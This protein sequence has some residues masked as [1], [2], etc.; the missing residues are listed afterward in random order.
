[1]T[2]RN[3]RIFKL[4]LSALFLAMAMILPFVTGQIPKLGNAFLPMH[5]PILLCGFF[6]GPIY[7]TVVGAVAP[8]LRFLLFG[9]P[10]LM[11]MGISMS[12]ELATYGL[13]A[14]LL[15]RL[16]PKK[17]LFVYLSLIG[18]MIAGRITWGIARVILYGMGQAPFGW[19]A[20]L[21]GAFL[22]AIPGIVIQIL[23]IPPL[24]ILL[25]KVYPRLNQDLHNG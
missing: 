24:V 4:V 12:F 21:S 10:T 22:T 16:L 18:S 9:M 19:Q 2:T 5:L 20:F 11:P 7:G 15:F 25:A 3:N 23:L 17:P 14:G 8:Y 13:I 1:M 6:C